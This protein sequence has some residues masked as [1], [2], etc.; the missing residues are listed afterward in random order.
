MI[1]YLFVLESTYLMTEVNIPINGKNTTIQKED[2]FKFQRQTGGGVASNDSNNKKR[3]PIIYALINRLIPDEWFLDETWGL[4]N[5]RLHEYLEQNVEANGDNYECILL[6]G[7]KYNHDFDI[8][9]E[10]IEFKFNARSVINLPQIY[11]PPSH[12]LIFSTPYAEF[13]YD[14]GYIGAISELYNIPVPERTLWLKHIHQINYDKLS[15]F[16]DLKTNESVYKKEKKFLV[17]HS[18]HTYLEMVQQDSINFEEITE[19][20]IPQIEKKFMLYNGGVFH[21]DVITKDECTIIS[22]N[23]LMKGKS[24]MYNTI[25]FNT[26]NETTKMHFLLRWRNHA[27]ILMPMWQ[28]KIVRS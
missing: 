1:L 10:E 18:I 27:G 20:L 16:R 5:E 19:L 8:N 25:V 21:N 28:I 6:A 12:K 3:E 17:D 22:L 4:V 11:S 24:G 26:R 13:F 23:S 9:G 7:R 14:N 2:I 15:W